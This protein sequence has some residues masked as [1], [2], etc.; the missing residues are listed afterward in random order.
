MLIAIRPLDVEATRQL[1][2]A[3]TFIVDTVSLKER[4]LCEALFMPP[5]KPIAAQA[6]RLHPPTSQSEATS[7]AD[8]EALERRQRL[9]QQQSE[10]R[11]DQPQI[12]RYRPN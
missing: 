1:G 5:V 2:S 4:P 6:S 8:S 9:N 12:P 3:G 7:E 11:I 10:F